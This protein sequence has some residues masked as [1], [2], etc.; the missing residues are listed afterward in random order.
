MKS[1]KFIIVVKLL[2]GEMSVGEMCVVDLTV[3]KRV[4]KIGEMQEK[5]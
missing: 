2:F 3:M 4:C 1:Q 5:R